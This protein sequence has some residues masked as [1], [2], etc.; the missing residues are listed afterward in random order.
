MALIVTC[1]GD[2]SGYCSIGDTDI[3]TAPASTI[4]S[5]MTDER[6]GRSMKK[7][8]NTEPRLLLRRLAVLGRFLG[9][10]FRLARAARLADLH[11]L[12]RN[13]L[14]GAFDDHA[15]A[16]R[17]ARGDQDAL[18]VG[19]VSDHHRPQLGGTVLLDDVYD[20]ALRALLDG[21]LGH[22]DRLRPRAAFDA[23]GD[24]HAGPKLALRVREHRAH[25]E[26]ARV[27]AEGRVREI[28][29][30]GMRERRAVGQDQLDLE[31]LI[32]RRDELTFL[33]QIAD[34][35]ELVLR[36]AESHPH[37]LDRR[38]VGELRALAH[39][40]DVGALPLQRLSAEAG[41]GRAYRRVAEVELRLLELRLR[42][43]HCG[44]GSVVLAL[45]LV[46]VGLRH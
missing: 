3:D 18:L 4:S 37:R 28:D 12:P 41:D 15:V 16:G 34:L 46:E 30:S 43:E 5:E 39:R 45:G 19:I 20:M 36:H 27:L 21:E 6:I 13:D 8:V 9:G 2:M 32:L 11:R 29:L 42:R 7:W 40:V 14:E 31:V 35:G 23:R 25:L 38:D 24:E 1:G 33:H 44:T 26:R 22:H 10:A 17:K